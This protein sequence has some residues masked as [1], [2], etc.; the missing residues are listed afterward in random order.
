MA[1]TFTGYAVLKNGN[2]ALITE[3]TF[4][5]FLTHQQALDWADL[6]EEEVVRVEIK[7]SKLV[8]DEGECEKEKVTA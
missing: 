1:E 2:F 3:G 8:G 4:Y 7:A 6:R 5:V